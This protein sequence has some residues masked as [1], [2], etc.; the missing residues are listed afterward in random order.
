MGETTESPR[1]VEM[2]LYQIFGLIETDPMEA[3]R[4]LDEVADQ[5]KTVATELR[6][7]KKTPW[8]VVSGS[9]SDRVRIQVIDHRGNLKQ[10]VDTRADEVLTSARQ[11]LSES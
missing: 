9:M 6:K 8:N 1:N 5:L 4:R 11:P 2:T 10:E 3:A 7:R